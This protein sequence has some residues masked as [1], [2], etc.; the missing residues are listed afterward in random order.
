V[1]ISQGITIVLLVNRSLLKERV[2]EGQVIQ[3]VALEGSDSYFTPQVPAEPGVWFLETYDG[4]WWCLPAKGGRSLAIKD[5]YFPLPRG[6]TPN[7]SASL[8][9]LVAAIG[10]GILDAGEPLIY[11]REALSDHDSQGVRKLLLE[12]AASPDIKARSLGL[13]ELAAR[14]DTRA[15]AEV[16]KQQKT[17]LAAPDSFDVLVPQ[18]LGE[19]RNSEP[20]SVRAL[21][22]FATDRDVGAEL[23]RSAAHALA[24]IHT[25]EAVPYLAMLLEEDDA[26]QQRNAVIGLS[27]FAN[28]VGIQRAEDGPGMPHLNQRRP[29]HYSTAETAEYLGFDES[30]SDAFVAFWRRW[31]V[32]H[33]NDFPSASP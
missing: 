14:G 32:E 5:L 26:V 7:E 23:R 33:Q 8:D 11:F 19:F 16:R 6:L 21:G 18:A 15:L 29:N 10:R 20:E 12:L 4:D 3:L 2:P 9:D 28:G 31:W 24:A 25:R 13:A 22:Q 17:L 30:R 27:F 1:R